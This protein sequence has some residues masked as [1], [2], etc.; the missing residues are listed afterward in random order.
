M[1]DPVD[2]T[3]DDFQVGWNTPYPT[4]PPSFMPGAP[5]LFTGGAAGPY[6]TI[7]GAPSELYPNIGF[8]PDLI[9]ATKTYMECPV[10]F[11][12]LTAPIYQCQ[13]GHIICNNC[14]NRIEFCGECRI[15]LGDSR[16]R[17][18]ALEYISQSMEV[19]CPNSTDGCEVL[20]TSGNLKIHLEVCDFRP[21][22]LCSKHLG[23]TNCIEKVTASSAINHLR[24]VHQVEEVEQAKFSLR[25]IAPP[26]AFQFAPGVTQEVYWNPLVITSALDDADAVLKCAVS[27]EGYISFTCYLLGNNEDYKKYRI[28]L[29]LD[30]SAKVA[31]IEW[32]GSPLSY[33]QQ[34]DEIP[35]INT[36]RLQLETLKEFCKPHSLDDGEEY[37]KLKVK[38]SVWKISD[39]DSPF[40]DCF[41][42]ADGEEEPLEKVFISSR[43]PNSANYSETMHHSDPEHYYSDLTCQHCS[44]SLFGIIYRCLQCPFAY[45]CKYCT[46]RNVHGMHLLLRISSPEQQPLSEVVFECAAGELG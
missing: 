35:N 14:I 15:P 20:T 12:I 18:V 11:E 29:E 28:K 26:S 39:D 34:P 27:R 43:S 17:N 2:D 8:R 31:R 33:R 45:Y 42:N 25:L 1:A 5:E 22:P 13:N 10:C 3:A 6:P 21:I 4:A 23:W 16:I 9:S 41:R 38:V 19:K 36:F 24:E 32:T 30:S 46:E 40:R 37:S 7:P 44:T